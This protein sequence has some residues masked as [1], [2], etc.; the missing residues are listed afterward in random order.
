[1]IVFRAL[2]TR[3]MFARSRQLVGTF[4]DFPRSTSLYR[5]AD[6]SPVHHAVRRTHGDKELFDRNRQSALSMIQAHLR[7]NDESPDPPRF[8]A[9]VTMASEL[10]LL[11]VNEVAQF[12]SSLNCDMLSMWKVMLRTAPSSVE[13][14]AYRNSANMCSL[15]G[16]LALMA[17]RNEFAMD[18]QNAALAIDPLHVRAT[19]ARAH[20]L[21]MDSGDALKALQYLVPLFV[22][23][24]LNISVTRFMAD[25]FLHILATIHGQALRL[26]PALI[27]YTL[28]A[29]TKLLPACRS[30]PSHVD[31]FLAI[32]TGLLL[33]LNPPKPGLSA[34]DKFILS[35]PF[36]RAC[37]RYGIIASK[38]FQECCARFRKELSL[39]TGVH[40]LDDATLDMA[41]TVALQTHFTQSSSVLSS[42]EEKAL[43]ARIP[44][45][46]HAL[47]ALQSSGSPSQMPRF[48]MTEHELL[49]LTIQVSAMPV[50]THER[51]IE[52]VFV[53]AGGHVSLTAPCPSWIGIAQSEFSAPF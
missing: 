13:A 37:S 17:G 32:G 42:E 28:V 47:D 53:H 25:L 34:A 19:V 24:D 14:A 6:I 2:R 41:V 50:L 15:L 45:L 49:V 52:F 4:N 16:M 10:H 20:S 43:Q 1:M 9:A 26:P 36:T 8:M 44:L 46:E 40:A 30:W 33:K 51:S 29:V 35:H 5:F 22:R 23:C 27:E 7:T 31:N 12:A 48:L 11:F 38:P 39:D 3:T 18:W 21:L